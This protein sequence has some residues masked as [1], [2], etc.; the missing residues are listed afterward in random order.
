[1]SGLQRSEDRCQSE[2]QQRNADQDEQSHRDRRAQDHNGDDPVRHHGA[3]EPLQD[4]EECSDVVGVAR[5]RA[6][7][8]A[9]RH[10][11]SQRW[12]GPGGVADDQLHRAEHRLQPVGHGQPVSDDTCDRLEHADPEHRE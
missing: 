11:P 12:A 1:L 7:N 8:L 2:D 9:G 4:V 10:L 5:D 3:H 6:D